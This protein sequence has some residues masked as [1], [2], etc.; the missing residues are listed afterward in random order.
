MAA[1]HNVLGAKLTQRQRA[2]L[3]LALSFFTWRSLVREAGLKPAA[4][5]RAVVQAI[6][7]AGET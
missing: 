7:C 2:V 4:A 3:H 6:R 5:V 1:Y